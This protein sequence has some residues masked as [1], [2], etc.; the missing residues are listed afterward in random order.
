MLEE[1]KEHVCEMNKR[2]YREGL[3]RWTMGNVSGRDGEA[4]LVVIKPSGVGF[5]ELTAGM[6]VVVD[7]EGNV[8]EGELAPSVDMP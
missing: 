5:E 2:I 7:M 4:G 1:V 8:V 3:V 6:M